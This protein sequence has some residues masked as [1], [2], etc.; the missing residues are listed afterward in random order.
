MNKMRFL[1]DAFI[2]LNSNK[3]RTGLTM[4]GIIIGVAAVISMLAIGQGASTSITESIQSIGTN[5][6]YVTTDTSVTNYQP[7]TVHDAQAI[8]ESPLAESIAAVAPSVQVNMSVSY[9]GVSISPT[10]Q[11]VTPEYE[12]VRNK[13]VEIGIFISESH[14][15]NAETVA[16]IGA[17]VVTD[18]FGSSVGVLGEKIRIGN[19]L[20]TVIGILEQKG[21]TSIGSSDNQILVPLSTANL[22]LVAKSKVNDVVNLISI[23]A[24]DPESMDQAINE[25]TAILQSQH[26]IQTGEDLDFSV[27][28]QEDITEAATSITQVLTIFLGGIGAISLLVGGIGIMNIMLVSVIERTKEIGLRKA[29]GARNRDIMLQFLMESLVIGLIGG[30]FGVALGWGISSL[31]GGVA[32]F[33]NTAFNPVITADS[34]LLATLFSIAIGLVF[35]LYPANRAAKLEPV[36]ALRTE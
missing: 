14:L 2:S 33:G 13:K 10:I 30:I 20:Y 36:E 17:D 31:I 27:N 5:L 6:L 26:N 3:L 22:R 18:L 29:L 34:I 9:N 25:I 7:L 12:S 15:E 1:T 21:G 24:I 16:V 4:L 28:S 8:E 19:T 32:A 11:G 35:G 23:S